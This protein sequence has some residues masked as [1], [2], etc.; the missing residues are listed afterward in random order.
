LIGSAR[1]RFALRNAPVALC[2]H[3]IAAHR[4]IDGLMGTKMPLQ[5]RQTKGETLIAIL[6]FS[7]CVWPVVWELTSAIVQYLKPYSQ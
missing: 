7:L 2:L 3:K 1:R 4:M 5:D 6:L